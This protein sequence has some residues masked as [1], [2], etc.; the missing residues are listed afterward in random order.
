VQTPEQTPSQYPWRWKPGESG[1]RFG[2]LSAKARAERI[3]A[4]AREL[5]VEFG[6]YDSLSPVDRTLI[7]QAVGLVLR[8]PKSA[9]DIVRHAN[10]VQRLLG[11]LRKRLGRAREPA[12]PSLAEYVA[13]KYGGGDGTA[14]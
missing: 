9:E 14:P 13:A 2:S 4:K 3:E 5:A 8:H 10:A 6:G 11:G 1:N 12:A 7:E